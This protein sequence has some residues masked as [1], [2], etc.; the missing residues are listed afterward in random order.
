MASIF[1]TGRNSIKQSVK[2]PHPVRS[3]AV[4]ESNGRANGNA[5]RSN[6]ESFFTVGMKVLISVA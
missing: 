5:D 6:Q 2:N 3:S 1:A 4:I